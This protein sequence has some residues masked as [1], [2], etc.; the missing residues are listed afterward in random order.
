MT[1]LSHLHPKLR[2][3]IEEGP[4]ERIKAINKDRWISYPKADETLQLLEELLETPKRER[5]PGAIVWAETNNGKTA[6]FKRFQQ[7]HPPDDNAEGDAIRYPVLRLQLP[8]RPDLRSFYTDVLKKMHATYRSSNQ[9]GN[10]RDQAI[11]LMEETQV[12][13]LI[14]DELHNVLLAGEKSQEQMF[15]MIRF[16]I[17]ELKIP[18]VC[19]GL[20]KAAI[21]LQT[22][23]QLAN[24]FEAFELPFWENDVEYRKF[25]HN[26]SK[27]IPLASD[28]KLVKTGLADMIFRKTDGTVGEFI[29]LIRKS[30]IWAIKNNREIIDQEAIDR[31][32][33]IHPEARR[34]AVLELAL[35]NN[36]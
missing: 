26:Y 30:A 18:I 19:G 23:S 28:S 3:L 8:E 21:A 10:L 15:V 24:R 22:D 17:N 2:N 36:P 31:S 33:Y 16:L 4:K 20:D 7:L 12:E 25:I 35:K 13:M 27:V 32:G 9:I 5:M 11:R 6:V 34:R 14:I 1:E 29:K